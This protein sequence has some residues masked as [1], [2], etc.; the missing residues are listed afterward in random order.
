MTEESPQVRYYVVVPGAAAQA[1]LR[2]PQW[3]RKRLAI[4]VFEV[5]DDGVGPRTACRTEV[6]F[7]AGDVRHPEFVANIDRS[8]TASVPTRARSSAR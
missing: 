7:S 5:T 4:D 2:V 3:V 1:A 6:L 8:G